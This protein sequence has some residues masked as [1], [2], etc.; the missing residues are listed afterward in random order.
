MK[1]VFFS[2]SGIA[3]LITLIIC[4]QNIAVTGGVG[5]FF[6]GTTGSLF[7]PFVLLFFLGNITGSCLVFGLMA[8]KEQ[9]RDIGG[10]F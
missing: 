7:G 1:K 9:P 6:G 2:V 4:F 5:I 8:K 10:G 3:A